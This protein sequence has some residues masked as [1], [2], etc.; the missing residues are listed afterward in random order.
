MSIDARSQVKIRQQLTLV[1]LGKVPA[2]LILR[3]GK[4]LDVA[5][6]TW[7]DDQEIITGGVGVEAMLAN[8]VSGFVEARFSD[9]PTAAH[10]RT[11]ASGTYTYS[12]PITEASIRTGLNYHF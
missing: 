9:Y 7:A 5:P 10:S 3:V 1:A 4:R 6:R 8:H 11:T 2:D 12:V